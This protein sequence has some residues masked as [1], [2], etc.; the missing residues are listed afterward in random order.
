MIGAAQQFDLA[1]ERFF[2]GWMRDWH[3]LLTPTLPIVA[4]PLMEVDESTAPLATFTRAVNYLGGCG[5]SLPA[6]FSAS[7]LPIGV[8]LI[9][10]PFTDATLIRIGRA[11]QRATGW[12]RERPE[13]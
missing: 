3:A 4:T 8:Q 5:L 12:H 6:G 11:F 2:A 7:R 9:G 13:I 1:F 10:G